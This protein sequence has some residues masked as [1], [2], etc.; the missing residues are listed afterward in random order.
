MLEVRGAVGGVAEPHKLFGLRGL[1][2]LLQCIY[3]E[4]TSLV[5]TVHRFSYTVQGQVHAWLKVLILQTPVLQYK[6]G[7]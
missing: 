6:H 2:L 3:V 4:K 7:S 1:G 5:T